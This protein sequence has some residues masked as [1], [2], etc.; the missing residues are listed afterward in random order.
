VTDRSRIAGE[1]SSL[2]AG[3][4]VNGLTA[5][6][7]IAI[8]T[9]ALGAD[10]FAPVAV[11]WSFW[12]ASAAVLT[13]PIQHWA[14]RRIEV[15]GGT[16][17]VRAS[18]GRVAGWVAALTVAETAVAAIWAE[19]LF[20][21]PGWFWP[22]AVAVLAL[23]S[24]ILG[25]ARGV[26]AG[27]GRYHAAAALIGGENLVRL[28]AGIGAVALSDDPRLLAAALLVGPLV[29]LGWPSAGRLDPA[30]APGDL[31]LIGSAGAGI[32]VSQV[33][34]NGG[35]PLLAVVGGAEAEVTALFAA[36]AVFRAPY[37]VALGLSVRATAPI[38]RAVEDGRETEIRRSTLA[39]VAAGLL[40]AAAAVPAG[41]WLAPPVLELLF[42]DGS[43]PAAA[44]AAAVAAGAVL[45]LVALG[46]TVVLIARGS[47][48]GVIATWLAGL[49]AAGVVLGV[50]TPTTQ[51]GIG[52]AFAVGEGAAVAVGT[53]LA[54]RGLSPRRV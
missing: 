24:A 21:D 11:L 7:F 54:L 25:L 2:L 30:T 37:L 44:T 45:A 35:P 47:R 52:V 40:L 18:L 53:A 51:E 23:G 17:S 28:A 22:T 49:A 43:R 48:V 5:Y 10:A 6:V 31:G 27:G 39:G 14:I 15:E 46:L 36:L 3:S 42:G 33:L 32:L 38:T 8:G 16:G 34:L 50:V 26:L 12:A 13:F 29:V 20:G 9:R 41:W 4:L 1:A 19:D